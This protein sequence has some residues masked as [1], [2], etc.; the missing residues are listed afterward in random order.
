MPKTIKEN[1]DK[2]KQKK[3]YTPEEN[4]LYKSY[5]AIIIKKYGKP[6]T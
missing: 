2:I 6:V 4:E 5:M 3:W 1:Q